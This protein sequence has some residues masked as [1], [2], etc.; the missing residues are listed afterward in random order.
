[1]KT[2]SLGSVS[3]R[4]TEPVKLCEEEVYLMQE[5][6]IHNLL[7]EDVLGPYRTYHI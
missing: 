2:W 6:G 1:M 5:S 7:T 3:C 4:C